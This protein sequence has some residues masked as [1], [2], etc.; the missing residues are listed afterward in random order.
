MAKCLNCGVE[1]S[2]TYRKRFCMDKCRV[3]YYREGGSYNYTIYGLI[4]PKT[5]LYFYV[6]CTRQPLEKRLQSHIGESINFK[7]LNNPLSAKQIEIIEILSGGDTPIIEEL[8]SFYGT[9]PQSL[10]V[11]EKW[12][13]KLLKNHPIKNKETKKLKNI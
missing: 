3:Y 8:F 10:L 6:G 11:E 2:G 5:D 12:V 1:M 7:R 4:N 9:R 13:S